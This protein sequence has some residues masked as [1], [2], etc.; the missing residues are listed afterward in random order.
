VPPISCFLVDND[1]ED[2]EIFL[3]ALKEIDP[4]ITCMVA[5]GARNA[6]D[7]FSSDESFLPKFIFIDMNMPLMNGIECLQELRKLEHLKEIPIYMY[8]TAEDKRV[9]SQVKILGATDI[10]IKPSSFRGLVDLLEKL[11]QRN[12]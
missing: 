10:I 2:Q 11:L 4:L 1:I 5:D 12:N 6:I 7:K 3:L 8:S 9:M